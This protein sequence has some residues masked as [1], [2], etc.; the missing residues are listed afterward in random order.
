MRGKFI[1]LLQENFTTK[2]CTCTNK[3]VRIWCNWNL[4]IQ[5]KFY[6]YAQ[7]TGISI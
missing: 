4:C 5:I 6:N 3:Y 2:T 7:C 1:Y